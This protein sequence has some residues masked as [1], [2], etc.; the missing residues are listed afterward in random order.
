MSEPSSQDRIQALV[1]DLQPVRPIPPLRAA[2]AAV[3]GT[4]LVVIA[5]GWLLG[6]HLPRAWTDSAWSDPRFL[7]ILVG[8]ALVACGAISAALASA[9]PGRE[10]AVQA[11]FRIGGL[12]L[13]FTIGSGLWGVARSTVAFGPGDLSAY[14]ACLASSLVLGLASC[15]V[16]C[17]FIARAAM[18]RP[19]ASAALA[20][21]GGV[22][23][24]AIA[25]HA[26]CSA[27][28]ALHQLVAH[29]SAPLVAAAVLTPLVSLVLIYAARRAARDAV[30]GRS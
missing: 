6:S 19:H 25:V 17:V 1:R 3:A 20:S 28:D 27:G 15:L 11:G 18:H 13:A 22:A 10:R 14:S 30:R 2:I 5:A 29:A 24:G 8:L 4:G 21:A 16:A 26:S 7:L 23:L 9:V 12:G